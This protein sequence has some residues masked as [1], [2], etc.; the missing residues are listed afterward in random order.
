MF[1]KRLCGVFTI[2]CS[3]TLLS[4][5]GIAHA[6]PRRA[7]VLKKEIKLDQL[8][9]KAEQ[10]YNKTIIAF[11]TSDNKKKTEEIRK[12]AAKISLHLKGLY[13]KRSNFITR[14]NKSA[15]PKK[16]ATFNEIV[17][18]T[19]LYEFRIRRVGGYAERSWTRAEKRDPKRCPDIV[20]DG[21]L[22]QWALGLAEASPS[23]YASSLARIVQGMECYAMGEAVTFSSD[24]VRAY[25]GTLQRF[26]HNKE[27]LS[28]AR[29]YLL[30]LKI[31]ET[32]L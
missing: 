3:L 1:N 26:G 23:L 21:V 5:A 20:S 31:L 6:Q 16:L 18:A 28:R 25:D 8:V 19:F 15:T 14:L 22:N 29:S 4:L 12:K 32:E 10:D 17:L 13:Q 2:V 30:S 9:L 7:G 27:F 24:L 11:R